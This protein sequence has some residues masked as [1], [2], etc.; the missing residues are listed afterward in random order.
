LLLKYPIISRSILRAPATGI[1]LDARIILEV[2]GPA[3]PRTSPNGW[4]GAL[5]F[6][7]EVKSFARNLPHRPG[8]DRHCLGRFAAG[9]LSAYDISSLENGAIQRKR[10]GVEKAGSRVIGVRYAM[11]YLTCFH[12]WTQRPH[13]PVAIVRHATQ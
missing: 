8:R 9:L 5:T 12:E 10:I 6:S 4:P 11:I 13:S 2:E 3:C 1:F 7:R